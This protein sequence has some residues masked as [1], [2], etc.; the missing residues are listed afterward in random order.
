[1]L[2]N[3]GINEMLESLKQIVVTEEKRPAATFGE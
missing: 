1:M 2:K 3:M